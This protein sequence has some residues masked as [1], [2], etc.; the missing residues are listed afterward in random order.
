LSPDRAVKILTQLIED[1]PEMSDMEASTLG[2]CA[3]PHFMECDDVDCVYN[4]VLRLC[5]AFLQSRKKCLRLKGDLDG[6]QE[7]LLEMKLR[8]EPISVKELVGE[9]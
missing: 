9:E 4:H 5:V 6:A 3:V 1:L 2:F 8:Y 7:A